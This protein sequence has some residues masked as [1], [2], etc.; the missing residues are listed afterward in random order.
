M[1]Q[2]IPICCLQIPHE[3]MY[4]DIIRSNTLVSAMG[5]ISAM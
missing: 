3:N 4:A 1:Q 2:Y 5:V